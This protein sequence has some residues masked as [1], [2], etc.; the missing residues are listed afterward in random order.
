MQ[1]TEENK[2]KIKKRRSGSV[3]GIHIEL[4]YHLVDRLDE[5][6]EKFGKTKADIISDALLIWL[7]NMDSGKW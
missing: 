4:N 5:Y 7:N 6:C 1:Q 3:V 2:Y